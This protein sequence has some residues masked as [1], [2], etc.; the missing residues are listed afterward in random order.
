MGIYTNDN[1]GATFSAS[2]IGWATGLDDPTVGQIMTNVLDAFISATPLP[3]EPKA[4]SDSDYF[5][6]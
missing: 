3:Q 4:S 6:L 2:S 5:F 1:G